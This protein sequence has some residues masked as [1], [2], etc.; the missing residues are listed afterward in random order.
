MTIGIYFYK[1]T[2]NNK[3]YIGQSINI[4]RRIRQHERSFLFEKESDITTTENIL[5]YRAVK[6][7]GRKNF[8]WGILEVCNRCFLNE[9]EQYYIKENNSHY[10]KNGYNLS[11]GGNSMSGE[12]HPFYNKKHTP[13]SIEKIRDNAINNNPMYGKHHSEETKRKISEASLRNKFN[14]SK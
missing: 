4:E 12:N 9:K 5:L 14:K 13:E 10:T 11:F 2:I 1:N 7:Y 3:T 6:K 8:I